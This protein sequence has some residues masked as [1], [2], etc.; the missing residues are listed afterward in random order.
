MS[1]FVTA[2]GSRALTAFTTL[3]L[4]SFLCGCAL[5]S[6]T[7]TVS[8]GTGLGVTAKTITGGLRGQVYG[9]Q[10]PI[11]GATLQLY[12]AGLD[13]SGTSTTTGYGKGATALITPGT[14]SAGFYPYPGVVSG[15]TYADNGCISASNGC[16]A[17]PTTNASGQFNLTGDYTCPTTSDGSPSEIY[18][19]ATGGNPGLTGTVNNQYATLMTALG[20][21]A[22]GGTLSTATAASTTTAPFFPAIPALSFI[23][24]NEVTTVAAVWALQ[25]FMAVPSAATVGVPNIGAPNT[26]YS[27]GLATPTSYFTANTGLINAFT[28]AGVLVDIAT[29]ASPNTHYKYSTPEWT[30]IYTIA[31]I[32]AYCV[33]SNPASTAY[34][35]NLM[36]AGTPGTLPTG[37]AA[38]ADIVQLAYYMAQ[39]PTLS[40]GTG[41]VSTSTAQT[42]SL[43][44]TSAAGTLY[45]YISG[46]QPFPDSATA[47]CDWTIA[48]SFLPTYTNGSTNTAAL[49]AAFNVA[50]DAY[51]NAWL[52][53]NGPGVLTSPTAPQLTAGDLPAAAGNATLIGTDGSLLGG[54]YFTYTA[55]TTPG[56]AGCPAT[57]SA[58]GA[59]P[60]LVTAAAGATA[61]LPSANRTFGTNPAG[62]TGQRAAG[63]DLN[64]QFWVGNNSETTA[65][66]AAASATL[67]DFGSV[68]VLPAASGPGVGGGT[69][70][71]NFGAPTGTANGY[72]TQY[73]P[74][75]LAIDGN[76]NIFTSSFSGA[77]GSALDGKAIAKINGTTGAFSFSTS[78]Q[79]PTGLGTGVTYP[80]ATPGG[81]NILAFDENSNV[82][83][84]DGNKGI[85]YD[86][87]QGQCSNT[88][89]RLGTTN[90]Q[91]GAIKQYDDDLAVSTVPATDIT[92]LATYPAAATAPYS[93]TICGASSVISTVLSA[94]ISEP[95][96][97]AIDSGSGVWIGDNHNNNAAPY[98]GFDGLTYIVAPSSADAFLTTSAG[99]VSLVNGVASNGSTGATLG[100]AIN[101][102]RGM[103]VDGNNHVWYANGGLQSIGEAAYNSGTIS[104]LTPNAASTL[105]GFVHQGIYGP[106]QVAID[107]SGNVWI[108]NSTGAV[109]V[110]VTQS[111]TSTFA[112]E[113]VTVLVGAAGPLVT[114]LSLAIHNNML[115]KKP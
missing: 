96:A 49:S 26:S 66:G 86:S 22:S 108:A 88:T 98:T 99:S 111:S 78:G 71:S 8:T 107:P 39:N 38:P 87:F 100:T 43:C 18:L 42:G 47:P 57:S 97:I 7:T 75:A 10:Q 27:N 3:A 83:A 29:G 45:K 5:N 69:V 24:I 6:S 106:N 94:Y 113:Q 9:G 77:S 31:D 80:L 89:G 44:A 70:A 92:T 102:P 93:S 81:Y 23:N 110:T 63:I 52:D 40:V 17:L 64:N 50:I 73:M 16:L 68:A 74:F 91:Y 36:T 32:F 62:N 34:C 112:A 79:V 55:A 28:M 48:V 19:V 4:A 101:A 67:P 84:G 15:N 114:P 25:Q 56:T 30:K 90:V 2:N 54:P 35:T 1:N 12:A 46:I 76:N 105:V 60:Q 104:L 109:G 103:L 58:C 85:L 41:T 53:S 59:Y 82:S 61:N 33:N 11:S 37:G 51:G 72:F 115:G 65:T 21:C 20:P 95:F 14:T 13:P